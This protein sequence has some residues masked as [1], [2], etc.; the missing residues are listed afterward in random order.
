MIQIQGYKEVSYSSFQKVMDLQFE[1]SE[2]TEIEIALAIKVKSTATIKNA[3]RK[4]T[5]IVSDEVMTNVMK[6]IELEGFILWVNAKRFYYIK[7]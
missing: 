1:K 4:D 2:L 5:Q 3:F 6:A 7:Q